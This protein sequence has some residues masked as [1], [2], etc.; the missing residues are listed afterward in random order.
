M[1]RCP[2][3]LLLPAWIRFFSGVFLVIGAFT[4]VIL[5]GVAIANL[6]GTVNLF[7]IRYA[8]PLR[9]WM[10]AGMCIVFLLHGYAGFA[11]LWGRREGREAG[12]TAG[13]VGLGLCAIG[14]FLAFQD[15]RLYIPFEPLFQVPFIV[16]LHRLKALWDEE[17]NQSPEP[18]VV[19][20]L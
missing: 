19:T 7:G 12:L 8:G 17:P 18:T 5:P 13:Y 9:D 11:L 16:K 10:T 14:A 1:N 3:Y 15:G 2:R 20:D 4:T 6:E